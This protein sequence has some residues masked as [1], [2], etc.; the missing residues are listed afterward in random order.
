[1]EDFYNTPHEIKPYTDFMVE[2]K[3]T[4]IESGDKRYYFVISEPHT[5]RL[6]T[7]EVGKTTFSSY[8]EGDYL[9]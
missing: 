1:M 3:F 5:Y 8:V 6:F 9:E 4:K 7:L 2:D